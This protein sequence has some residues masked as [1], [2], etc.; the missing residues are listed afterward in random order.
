LA[1][2]EWLAET[3]MGTAQKWIW[4]AE[5]TDEVPHKDLGPS[6]NGSG[7]TSGKIRQTKVIGGQRK[8]IVGDFARISAKLEERRA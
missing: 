6:K 3:K 2:F 4:R 7:K 8:G 5:G 1:V